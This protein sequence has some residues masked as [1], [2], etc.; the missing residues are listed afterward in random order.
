M[1]GIR[2]HPFVSFIREGLC[3]VGSDLDSSTAVNS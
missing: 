3:G 2:S 1:D